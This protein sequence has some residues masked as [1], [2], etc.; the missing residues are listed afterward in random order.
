MGLDAAKSLEPNIEVVT[1]V[2]QF[3]IATGCWN[4]KN[5]EGERTCVTGRLSKLSKEAR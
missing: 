2:G 5:R 3:A 4:M 1:I